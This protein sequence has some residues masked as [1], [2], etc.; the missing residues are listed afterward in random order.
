MYECICGIFLVSVLNF[1]CVC[2]CMSARRRVFIN[3]LPS[4]LPYVSLV[5]EARR[6]ATS[7]MLVLTSRDMTPSTH[8][9]TQLRTQKRAK[10][11]ITSQKVHF[12]NEILLKD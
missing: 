2:G 11:Q 1:L 6:W 8:K 4:S 12:K 9:H 7:H 5:P 3:L 10:P